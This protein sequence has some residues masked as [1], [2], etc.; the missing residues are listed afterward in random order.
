MCNICS[1]NGCNNPIFAKGYCSKHYTQIR[2]YGKI[3]EDR[4]VNK[5]E[6]LESYAEIYLYNAKHEL[7]AKTLIDID[8]IEKIKKYK[9]H[10]INNR[11][12]NFYVETSNKEISNRLLHRFIMDAPEGMV[13]D[14]INRNPLDNRKCNLR[15]C[16]NTQNMENCDMRKNN[17]SG[18]K[19]VYWAKD[20]NKW[21]VQIGLNGKTKYIGRFNNYE[22]A[23]KAR[24]EAVEK[25]YGKFSNDKE[26]LKS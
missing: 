25:Y 17:T 12:K 7:V 4:S 9:W 14:H 1:I 8:D 10:A 15:I 21:T 11:N 13:V 19:G 23:V 16:T 2:K 3:V 6:I 24:I 5:I 22:D 20:K 26:I 18:C